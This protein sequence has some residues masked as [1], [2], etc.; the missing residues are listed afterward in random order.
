MYPT[1]RNGIIGV[2]R[3][4]SLLFAA[5]FGFLSASAQT[6]HPKSQPQSSGGQTYSET[7]LHSFLS[8]AYDGEN[9]IS[10][11]IQ[12]QSGNMYGATYQNGAIGGGS[13][14]EVTPDGNG[15]I[16]YNPNIYAAGDNVDL[17]NSLSIDS[18]GNLYGTSTQG[19]GL[20]TG[21]LFELSQASQGN[22][23]L[24]NLYIF[25]GLAG[26][27][28]QGA[29][30]D[31]AGN[32]YGT[33]LNA[34]AN[35][36]GT[37]FELQ[38]VDDQW[39]EQT[40]VAFGSTP[41]TGGYGNGNLLMDKEGNLYGTTASGG[42]Y[43]Q[44]VVFKLHPTKTGWRETILHAFQGGAND[45]TSVN[46]PL[47]FGPDGNIYGTTAFGLQPSGQGYG[48]VFQLTK[49]GKITWV[50]TF[51]AG[52]D[53]TAPAPIAGTVVFDQAGNLY[54]VSYVGSDTGIF[55]LSPPSHN[56]AAP[57]TFDLIY[58]FS[59][60]DQANGLEPI[61]PFVIDDAGNIYGV[62]YGGGTGFGGVGYGTIFKLTPN[63]VATNTSITQT[64][65]DPSVA[66]QVVKVNFA[67]A[68]TVAGY[69]VPSG[70]VTVSA[71]TGEGCTAALPLKGKGSCNLL[72]A[73]S[74]ARGLTASY[75]G[76]AGNLASVSSA[77]TE[78]TVSLTSTEI[79]KDTPDPAK[80][81]QPVTVHFSV[82]AK[83][84]TN[85]T[86]PSGNVTVN[87]STG[88]SCTGTLSAGG[89]GKCQIT[90][91]SAGSRTLT[92]MYAGDDDNAGSVSKSVAETVE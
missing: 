14:F 80:V 32:V 15:G 89:T 41:S 74:G 85:K 62:T 90:F 52:A 77:V 48:G 78:N 11:L 44:G 82:E 6:H 17:L 84:G 2:A 72:F 81:G 79:T 51:T 70:T 16:T 36:E 13:V 8:Q 61:P 38:N 37:I 88:E 76:D 57:W 26:Q 91:S 43:G 92:A 64:F 33:T 60:D 23:I 28:P 71:S 83:N 25:G 58:T 31:S 7:V 3:T 73:T 30:V 34:G 4:I 24:S 20:V 9:P 12:D 56:Q 49:S 54:G 22:W 75:S 65:P 86:R 1:S 35:E 19:N 18:Q 42:P 63:P 50:W 27:F 66:G 47:T 59:S 69:N 29:T 5:S 53:G 67:V 10:G 46:G 87:A 39:L 40:L 68:Q 55:K 21:A 45:G